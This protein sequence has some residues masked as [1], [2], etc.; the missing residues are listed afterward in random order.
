MEELEEGTL[1]APPA[2][3]IEKEVACIFPHSKMTYHGGRV[4]P[5]KE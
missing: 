5:K 4:T 1:G 3:L 2:S